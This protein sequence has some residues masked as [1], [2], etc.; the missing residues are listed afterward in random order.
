MKITLQL[1]LALSIIFSASSCK[2]DKNDDPAPVVEKF[3][4]QTL[5]WKQGSVTGNLVGTRSND[6][7]FDYNFDFRGASTGD[8]WINEDSS[9][10]LR[11][12]RF[13]ADVYEDYSNAIQIELT[14]PKGIPSTVNGVNW[15]D[16][17]VSRPLTGTTKVH[18]F[19][20]EWPK[21]ITGQFLATPKSTFNFTNVKLNTV[22]GKFTAD[23]LIDIDATEN[24][25]GNPATLQGKI[26]VELVN[27]VYRKGVN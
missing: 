19:E 23:Y 2:K 22:T 15:F 25:S 21:S 20:F 14:I 27:P 3:D 4:P 16:V 12:M 5:I 6:S 26:D 9:Y 1:L 10:S 17:I 7:T 8:F 18:V 13:K 11:L 24:K